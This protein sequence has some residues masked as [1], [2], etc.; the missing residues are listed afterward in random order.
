M[1]ATT[2]ERQSYNLTGYTSVTLSFNYGNSNGESGDVLEVRSPPMGSI[3]TQIATIAGDTS[4][5]FSQ[6]ISSYIAANTGSASA[7]TRGAATRQRIHL[8]WTTSTSPSRTRPRL[9]HA[10]FYA[11]ASVDSDSAPQTT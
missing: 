3:W 9:P 6:D 1:W 5:T 2:I 4:G 8:L 10:V 7:S 11:V